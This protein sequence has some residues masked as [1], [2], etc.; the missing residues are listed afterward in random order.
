MDSEFAKARIICGCAGIVTVN[1]IC[2]IAMEG[3]GGGPAAAVTFADQH[4]SKVQH[5]EAKLCAKRLFVAVEFR[6]CIVEF[7]A[8]LGYRT[9]V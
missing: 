7:L 6:L 4:T 1:G 5:A 9:M 2:E 8:T 3:G